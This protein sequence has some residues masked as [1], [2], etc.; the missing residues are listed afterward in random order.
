MIGL[1]DSRKASG[2]LHSFS[3]DLDLAEWTLELGFH[4]G[5]SGPVTYKKSEQLKQVVHQ[6]DLD[7]LLIETDAPFLTPSPHRGR[8]NEPAY[9]RLVAEEVARQ[10]EGDVADIARRTSDNAYS[11]FQ[12]L[13][14]Q[15][16]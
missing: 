16:A 9:V 15:E 14:Q 6:I 12:R 10:R 7:R 4:V 2:V 8:R 5:V 13:P 11:L 1:G 3:G